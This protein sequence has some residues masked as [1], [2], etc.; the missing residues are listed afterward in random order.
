VDIGIDTCF[1]Y[2]RFFRVT[3][4]ATGQL[5]FINR[6]LIHRE[7]TMRC[8]RW[9]SMLVF[10]L[11][12]SG[13]NGA[14]QDCTTEDPAAFA[15]LF[16]CPFEGG[17]VECVDDNEDPQFKCTPPPGIDPIKLEDPGFVTSCG[18]INGC[19]ASC[20]KFVQE[21]FECAAS[22]ACYSS[23]CSTDPALCTPCV[24]ELHPEPS[25]MLDACA[26]AAEF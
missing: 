19:P 17:G 18:E 8:V 15:D 24:V 9:L 7:T 14:L 13:A 5:R 11:V 6:E 2:A 21:I 10:A 1:N 25:G 4:G 12:A 16:P 26:L 22:T 23:T 3:Y 20:C